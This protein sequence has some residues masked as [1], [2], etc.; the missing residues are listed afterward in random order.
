MRAIYL[1]YFFI[2]AAPLMLVT[3]I[4]AALLVI[5]GSLVGAGSAMGYYPPKVWAKVMCWLTIVRVTVKGRENI[6]HA[7]SYM[8]VANHQGAYD[9]FAIYGWLG[10]NFKWMMKKSL[11][12]IPMVGYACEKSGHIMVDKSSPAAVRRT[13]EAAKNTLRG[14]MSIVVFPEGARTMTGKVGPFKKGAYQLALEFG[15]PM[16]PITIDGAFDVFPRM[17]KLPRPGHIKVTIHKP[18]EAPLTEEQRQ[19]AIDLTREAIISGLT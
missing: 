19:R 12:K 4:L 5:I 8:F 11:R 17:A 14:G 9:I 3:T 15:L 2:V 13:V 18:V 1:V 10:H 7:T 6:N 16:V